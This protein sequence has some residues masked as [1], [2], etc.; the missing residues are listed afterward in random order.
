[1]QSHIHKVQACL[2]VTCHLHFLAEWPGS[3]TAVA[4]GWNKYQNKSPHRKLTLEKKITPLLLQGFEPATFQ[5]WVQCSNHWAIPALCQQ[6]NQRTPSPKLLWAGT[7]L[8]TQQSTLSCQLHVYCLRLP[9]IS[10]PHLHP[11]QHCPLPLCQCQTSGCK[12][13]TIYDKGKKKWNKILC[14]YSKV[15]MH[16]W[17]AS[18][19]VYEVNLRILCLTI[20]KINCSCYTL[21]ITA[22][23]P[24]KN[25]WQSKTMIFY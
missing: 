5:S 24:G 20:F 10:S 14:K 1:M 16:D 13:S 12:Q 19:T 4:R 6:N 21:I 3:F 8:T 23:K 7:S 25:D 11:P 9:Y 2:A 18:K 17:C 22:I 15:H